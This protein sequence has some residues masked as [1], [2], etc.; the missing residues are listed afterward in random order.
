MFILSGA[1]LPCSEQ[2]AVSGTIRLALALCAAAAFAGL[3]CWDN[4]TMRAAF[5]GLWTA[6]LV[7]YLLHVAAAFHFVHG[8]SHAHAYA[9]TSERTAELT[10]WRFGGGL[11]VNY[12]FSALWMLHAAALWASSAKTFRPS[13]V[14]LIW[15]G[16]FLF[17]VVNGAIVFAAGPTRWLSTAALLVL[18]LLWVKRRRE[19]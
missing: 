16:L 11:W 12:L 3:L 5:R 17:M 1:F 19:P 4:E 8:W 18:G 10:G 14:G 13:A 2:L 6:G 9:H 7:F 15:Y